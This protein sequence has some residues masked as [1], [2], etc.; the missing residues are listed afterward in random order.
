MDEET[1]DQ[2]T[3]AFVQVVQAL[4]PYMAPKEWAR[5][6]GKTEAAIKQDLRMGTVA[7][8]Q[9]VANG[10]VYV[11]VIKEIERAENAPDY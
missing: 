6:V 5:L 7:R 1:K 4:P 8:Y 2:Q 9:P 11:N 10:R 3:P